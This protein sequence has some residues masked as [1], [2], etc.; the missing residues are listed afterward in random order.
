MPEP[1][2]FPSAGSGIA[3]LKNFLQ[4]ACGPVHAEAVSSE[5]AR[6]WGE[7]VRPN[8]DWVGELFER[9]ERFD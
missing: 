8:E 6:G 9:L 7:S 4:G 3:C 1:G 2:K 5:R